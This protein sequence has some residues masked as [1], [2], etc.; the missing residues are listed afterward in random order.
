MGN[1]NLKLNDD[2]N[3]PSDEELMDIEEHLHDYDDYDD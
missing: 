3:G 1:D 2:Y